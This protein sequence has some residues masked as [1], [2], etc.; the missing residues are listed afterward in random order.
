MKRNIRKSNKKGNYIL[1][2]VITVPVFIMAVMIIISIVPIIG[3]CER[4]TY[5]T[6]DEMTLEAA[7]SYF[8]ENPV[9]LPQAVTHRI[10]SEDMDVKSYRIKSYKY[11][12]RDNGIDDLISVSFTSV[13]S[14]KNPLGLFSSVVFDGKVVCRGFTGTLHKLRPESAKSEEKDNRTVYIFPQWG[15]RYHDKDC[16]YVKSNCRLVYLSQTVKKSYSPCK[17]CKAKNSYI[18]TP[19]FCFSSSGEVYHIAGC[20]VIDKY[21]VE[22]SKGEAEQKG[23]TPCTKCGGG[24]DQ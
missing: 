11:L 24:G 15:M 4:I 19:V 10:Y 23:Y 9:A 20:R 3:D 18:G 2:A 21:Y 16:T 17:L 8:R 5:D 12:Y 22:V 1:E 14:R 13:F 7:K 6:V